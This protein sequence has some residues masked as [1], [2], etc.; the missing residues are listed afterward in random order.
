MAAASSPDI[1]V[2]V[3]GRNEAHNLPACAAALA[4]LASAGLAMEAIFIDSASSDASVAVAKANFG[5]VVELAASAELNAGAARAVGTLKARGTWVLYLDGD[6]QLAPDF[7]P[8]LLELVRGERDADGLAGRTLNVYPDGS[9]DAIVFAGNKAG[10]PCRAFGGAVLLRRETVLDV[11]NWAPNL[12][13]NEEAELYSR[14]LARAARVLWTE[15]LMVRHVTAKFSAPNKLM[16]SLVPWGSH[17]GKKFYGAGQVTKLAWSGGHL[18]RFIQLKPLPY[19]MT[20]AT[21]LA[22]PVAAFRPTVALGLIA[23]PFLL[24]SLKRGPKFAIN[25][26]CWTSQVFFGFARLNAAYWPEV[27][28]VHE[29]PASGQAGHR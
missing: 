7:I 18:W 6:M 8:H 5:V 15:S 19:L 20:V 17:L 12:Y 2:C 14:L 25:C 24:I 11:G 23:V 9:S 13:A 4:A 29:A 28:H 3:I 16:G 27:Q 21:T 22:L 1:S 26:V 10:Q